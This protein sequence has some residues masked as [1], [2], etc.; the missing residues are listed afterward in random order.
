M[1]GLIYEEEYMIFETKPKLL[2]I[3]T[4]TFLEQTISLLHFG[5]LEVRSTE[6]SNPK[7]GTLDIIAIEVVLSTMKSEYFCV[8]PEVSLEDKVYPKTYYHHSKDDIQV[9]ETPTK[10]QV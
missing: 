4:I 6:E 5:V 2:S 8:R 7:Q 10:I 9:D 1:E 3:G